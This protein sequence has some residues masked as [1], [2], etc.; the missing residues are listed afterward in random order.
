MSPS[1][2]QIPDLASRR[3]PG[4]GGFNATILGL[5]IRRLL[6]NKRTLVQSGDSGRTPPGSE[7]PAVTAGRSPNQSSR[8]SAER[9]VLRR[10]P[11][12]SFRRRILLRDADIAP[13]R[14]PR[15]CVGPRW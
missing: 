4:L 3:A 7:K 14:A 10:S 6:R 13:R 5:E 11:P 2:Q 8:F 12:I 1:P 9:A 15:H